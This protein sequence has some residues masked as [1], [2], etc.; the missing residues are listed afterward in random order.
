[1]FQVHFQPTKKQGKIVKMWK[2]TNKK[3]P[4]KLSNKEPGL[5]L[6]VNTTD[7][8]NGFSGRYLISYLQNQRQYDQGE[9]KNTHVHSIGFGS[10]F[11]LFCPVQKR[12][13]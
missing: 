11:S 1:M 7:V 10:N 2:E 8:T 6:D 12:T 3:L 13:K 4:Y 5:E 9:G